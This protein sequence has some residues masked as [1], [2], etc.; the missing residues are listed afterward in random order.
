MNPKANESCRAAISISGVA[1][2]D[3]VHALSPELTARQSIGF[4]KAARGRLAAAVTQVK[5]AIAALGEE[6]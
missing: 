2:A 4:L 5:D 3:L 1:I 6:G